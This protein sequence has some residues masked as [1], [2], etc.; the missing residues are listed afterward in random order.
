MFNI[1]QS[2]HYGTLL[3]SW[4]SGKSLAPRMFK[5]LDKA[6][7]FPD[8]L[9]ASDQK[10]L[11]PG[12]AEQSLQSSSS[13]VNEKLY[14]MMNHGESDVA[15]IRCWKPTFGKSISWPTRMDRGCGVFHG[16]ISNGLHWAA[17]RKRWLFNLT[18]DGKET[19]QESWGWYIYM[20]VHVNHIV[21]HYVSVYM[22]LYMYIFIYKA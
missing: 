20:I 18:V 19:I 5:E 17:W 22:Y 7:I 2:C 14:L 4:I 15:M 16:G 12:L 11:H 9:C 13:A 6:R 1:S 8:F 21:N 3:L 10:I